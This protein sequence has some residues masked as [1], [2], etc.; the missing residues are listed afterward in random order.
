[1][2]K[3]SP[4]YHIIGGGI[5][6]L[7]VAKFLRHKKPQAKIIIYEATDKLGGRC[8]SYFDSELGTELDEATHVILGANKNALK[9][10]D[11]STKFGKVQF[12]DFEQKNIIGNIFQAK[13]DI[14][15]AIFNMPLKNV[16]SAIL[17]KVLWKL[18][19]FCASKLKA[20]HS[21]NDLSQKLIEPLKIY[22]DEI[23]TGWKLKSFNAFKGR[24]LS[25]EFNRGKIVIAPQDQI[26]SALDAHNYGKI[27]GRAEFEYNEIINIHYRTSMAI[28]LPQNRTFMGVLKAMSQW[29]FANSGVLSVTISDAKNCTDDNDVLAR[30][31]WQEICDIRGHEAAFM[32]AYRVIR[33]K[34]AT[35]KQNAIN[36]NLR[37]KNAQTAWR[38]LLIAG[39]WT[40]RNYPCSIE[41]AIL[42]AKRITKKL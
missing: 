5:A 6:G 27:F 37:P 9:L 22:A 35:I 10:L 31:V 34:R 11:E 8:K 42:S 32:P 4:T 24:I 15:L 39:D 2:Q 41:A 1:M 28:T 26:I 12:Y 25:L 3:N 20:Y 23:K 21:Q 33:H 14:G 40:M 17:R 29:V 18:V 19:P 13:N 16:A 36:N 30:R 38:N 7:A